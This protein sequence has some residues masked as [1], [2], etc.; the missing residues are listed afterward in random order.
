MAHVMKRSNWSSKL[1]VATALLTVGLAVQSCG[2]PE[3]EDGD[4]GASSNVNPYANHVGAEAKGEK[5]FAA[6]INKYADGTPDHQP[7]ANTYWPYKSGFSDY[8]IASTAYAGGTGSPASKY[9]KAYGC[10]S[11]AEAWE[12]SYHGPKPPNV[13][14]ATPVASW[15]GH[16][17]GWSASASLFPEPPESKVVNGVTFSRSDIKAL[18]TEVG[19]LV[20]ADYFGNSVD[21][22]GLDRDQRTQDDTYPDQFMIVLTN[23]MGIKKYGI[24]IDRYTGDEIWNQP[25]AAYHFDYPK[26]SDYLGA[27]PEHPNVYRM[28]LTAHLWWGDDS[29][30]P[31]DQ[32]PQFNYQD[33]FPYFAG[34]ELQMEVWLDGPVVFNGDKIASSGDL[35]VTHQ[36]KYYVGGTWL[37]NS[38]DYQDGHPDFMWVPYAYLDA[39]DTEG[40]NKGLDANPYV[41]YKWVTKHFIRDEGD[42]AGDS[43]CGNGSHPSPSSS[44][45]PFPTPSSHPTS[46]PTSTPTAWPTDWPTHT[47]TH[48]PTN[49]PE[50]QPTPSETEAP[51]HT[52]FP[53]PWP[54]PH[55]THS[56]SNPAAPQPQPTS[57]FHF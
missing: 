34:R 54:F 10:G 24:N 19:M 26:P 56:E 28:N 7:W 42:D 22:G 40:A 43:S 50:P 15:W 12:R 2:K 49:W 11:R 52:P 27:D 35:I 4:S 45:S 9:D 1:A 51:P 33:N 29:A 16:C 46:I 21:P 47:P 25:L 20:S 17:N 44:P 31:N 14:P 53:L 38:N 36:D 30:D 5:N 6:L 32:T 57:T 48:E 8:G 18:E 41:D 23:Y 55:P 37:G 3:S 13:S 39:T